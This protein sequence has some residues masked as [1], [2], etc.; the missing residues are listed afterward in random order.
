MV[1]SISKTVT[2]NGLDISDSDINT[3]TNTLK[4]SFKKSIYNA[5]SINTD[6]KPYELKD[7]SIKIVP[8]DLNNDNYITGS[9]NGYIVFGNTYANFTFQFGNTYVD[10]E[11]TGS[12]SGTIITREVV[13]PLAFKE[14]W[15]IN[16]CL[17]DSA[18][19]TNNLERIIY[20]I[21]TGHNQDPSNTRFFIANHSEYKSGYNTYIW[22]AYGII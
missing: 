21:R 11:I 14:V 3:L 10:T 13:Y 17:Q 7:L 15:N 2:D 1:S 20:F 18:L 16:L 9:A 12:V 4:N 22:Q 19:S 6:T 5:M 8:P